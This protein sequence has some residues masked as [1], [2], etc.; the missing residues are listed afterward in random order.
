MAPWRSRMVCVTSGA[1]DGP[2]LLKRACTE[3]WNTGMSC[4]ITTT[5]TMDQGALPA[6]IEDELTEWAVYLTT[7]GPPSGYLVA[8]PVC[9]R[10]LRTEVPEMITP[11]PRRRDRCPQVGA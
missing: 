9:H 5:T 6:G 7:T 8:S 3:G 4:A 11:Q 2:G 1:R 10:F